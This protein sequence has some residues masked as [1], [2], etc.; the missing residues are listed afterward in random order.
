[1]RFKLNNLYLKQTN[2]Y[3]RSLCFGIATEENKWILNIR[4]F[5]KKNW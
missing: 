5:K 4:A 3:K 1:M 2:F